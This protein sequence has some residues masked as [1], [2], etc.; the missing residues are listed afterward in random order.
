MSPSQIHQKIMEKLGSESEVNVQDLTGTADHYRV[1]VIS[2]AFEGKSMIDQHRLVKSAFDKD[3]ASGEV[4]ALT[5]KTFTPTE[6]E[7]LK[8]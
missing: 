6:W 7:K 5:L 4:H 8:G 2:P 3:I 1:V